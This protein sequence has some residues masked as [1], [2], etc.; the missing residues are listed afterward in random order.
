MINLR[1]EVLKAL[2]KKRIDKLIGSPLEA[3]VIITASKEEYEF[4][5][6]YLAD[7]RYIFIVSKVELIKGDKLNIQVLKA[8]GKKCSRCWNWS[9]LVGKD[10][11]NPTLCERCSG[12]VMEEQKG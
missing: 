4:L 10:Q 7:L 3:K 2:E 6:R 11:S 12:V 1:E 9:A 5:N 8:D